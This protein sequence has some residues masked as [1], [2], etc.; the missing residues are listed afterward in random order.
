MEKFF[1]KTL[2]GKAP[3][4]FYSLPYLLFLLHLKRIPDEPTKAVLLVL[5]RTFRALEV[6]LD[7]AYS[8]TRTLSKTGK[9][10]DFALP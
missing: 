5:A 4:Y 1:R 7:A 9:A 2:R 3:V 8:T 10:F 6:W